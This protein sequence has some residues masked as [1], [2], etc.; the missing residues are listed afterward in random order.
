[1]GDN[2]GQ[3]SLVCC[4]PWGR[5]VRHN[6]ATEQQQ[7]YPPPRVVLIQSDAF[8]K[9]SAPCPIQ[10]TKS[11]MPILTWKCGKEPMEEVLGKNLGLWASARSGRE[12]DSEGMEIRRL[13]GN[14]SPARPAVSFGNIRIEDFKIIHHFH[15][16]LSLSFY[17]HHCSRDI[18]VQRGPC[19][20]FEAI[21]V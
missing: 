16:F 8:Y 14:T 17:T 1:M 7:L 20:W 21:I 5:R 10:S 12:Q 3:G 6:W 18:Q 19:I 9:V 15:F 11:G 2:E 13:G 4:S